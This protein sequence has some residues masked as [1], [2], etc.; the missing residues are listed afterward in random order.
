MRTTLNIERVAGQGDGVARGPDGAVFVPLTL[1]GEVVEAEVA[2]ERGEVVG[3][4]VASDARVAPPCP[5]FGD[6]GG[7]ALQHW[8]PNPYLDWKRGQVAHALAREGLEA[9][10]LPTAATSAG[11]RR[12]V[13]LHARRLP[14]GTVALGFKARRSWRLVEI[15][16]CAIADPR[17][18]QALPALAEVAGAMFE[19]PKS[20]PSLHV[21]V[22]E[23]GLDVDV[24]GVERRTG[25]GL[26]GDGRARAIAAATA[27]DLARLSLAGEVLVMRRPPVVSFGP[28]RVVLPPGGFLQASPQAEAIMVAEVV[29]AARGARKVVDLFCGAGT[30][31]FPLA[32]IA[33]VLAADAGAEAVAALNAGRGSAPRLKPVT[34]HAR[35]LFRRPLSPFDLKGCDVA[36]LDPPR[37]GAVEQVRQLADAR[38][39]ERIA[40]VSCNPV[41]FARD[42]A[43]LVAAG[44]RLE[45]VLPVDQFLWSGHVELV[46]TFRR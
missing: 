3:L 14:D 44:H 43:V 42:A 30:F 40:Y 12:R 4:I 21:T 32:E 16:T 2:E 11:T 29:A 7:C 9:E 24:T 18:V 10:V 31:T 17:I 25:G 35:D 6:C 38:T 19:H 20:A 15:A 13:A 5:H 41:T 22:T 28:A 36:V 27:A 39:V 26:S 1:P 45:R 8:A 33:P 37:A 46:A 34:A 23:A